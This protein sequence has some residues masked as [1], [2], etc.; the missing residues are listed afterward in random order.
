MI[1]KAHYDRYELIKLNN[2]KLVLKRCIDNTCELLMKPLNSSV[3]LKHQVVLWID[4]IPCVS[5]ILDAGN[6]E[7]T[8]SSGPAGLVF[9]IT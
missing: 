3:S 1:N 7:N 4:W 2:M 8:F 5:L 6:G 9:Y